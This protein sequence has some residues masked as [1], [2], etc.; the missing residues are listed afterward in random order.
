M[1][2]KIGPLAHP[3]N[4]CQYQLLL[5]LAIKFLKVAWL[6]KRTK[7]QYK[8]RKFMKLNNHNMNVLC[9]SYKQIKD[10][11]LCDRINI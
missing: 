1:I 4:F 3:L 10:Y 2:G 5:C 6:R 11:I 9:I 7:S 8:F